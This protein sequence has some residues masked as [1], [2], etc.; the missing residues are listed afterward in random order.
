MDLSNYM[1]NHMNIHD[2]VNSDQESEEPVRE[3]HYRHKKFYD[4]VPNRVVDS[5]D[6]LDW[7]SLGPSTPRDRMWSPA[8]RLCPS[9]TGLCLSATGETTTKGL[10]CQSFSAGQ[11]ASAEICT[12]ECF[13][14]RT[15]SGAAPSF[16]PCSRL[17]VSR[18]NFSI[19]GHIRVEE[20]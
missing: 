9:A 20:F 7:S 1:R 3:S 13:N 10:E 14:P 6:V 19:L 2:N 18:G 17:F 5:E 11:H 12:Q 15:S 8:Q 16:T 4:T